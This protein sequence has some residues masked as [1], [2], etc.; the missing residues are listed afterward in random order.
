[1]KI[2]SIIA[3]LFLINCFF[4]TPSSQANPNGYSIDV[5]I[6]NAPGAQVILGYY[7]DKSMYPQDTVVLNSNG[8][9]L[10]KGNERLEQGMYIIFLPSGK[11]FEFLMGEDQHFSVA[12]DTADLVNNLEF[13]GS[14]ENELFREFQK[15]MD[16][17]RYY[18][19]DLQAEL[20]SSTDESQKKAIRE[21]LMALGKE[22]E[23][24][25][26]QLKKD[27]PDLFVSTFLNATLDVEVPE[28]PDG[29]TSSEQQMWRYNYY[30][31]HYFDNFKISD[32]RLLRSP[33]YKDKVMRYMEK[34]IPQIPDSIN[35]EIDMILA[36]ARVD[37]AV[38]RYLLVSFFNHYAQSK[39]MGMDAVTVHLGK[40]YYLTEAWWSSEE[41]L[42]D[43][44]E[45][46]EKLEPLLI[47]KVAPDVQ[48]RFV[49]A[50]HFQQA[51][52][53]TALKK[54][55]H[56]GS[57]F[58]LSEVNADF[59]VL[60]FWEATCGHCK[61]A[62][63]KIYQ[64]YVNELKPMG[65]EIVSISTLS[66]EDGKEKWVD[67]VNKNQTYDWI[68]AWNPYDYKYKVVYDIKTTPQIFILNKDKEIIGK[69]LGE[70][71]I[72]NLIEAY[73]KHNESI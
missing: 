36:E 8:Q 6:N 60:I 71:D 11:Y 44:K 55:P 67:F 19:E 34:V 59:T 45:K 16:S 10:L 42:S 37:S 25:I 4:F 21:K 72:K 41:F 68:N 33:L 49:P 52:N 13:K 70:D 22:R 73:K 53:D 3:G 62:I 38:Y 23:S 39:I 15:Y 18:A 26:K 51:A 30:K 14:Q 43:L 58:K 46:V 17:K 64:T 29:L 50:D 12:T 40:N 61:K 7:M 31:K 28:A 24:R 1:M 27:H 54:F 32:S 69:R 20:N 66:G 9:G 47:G 35:A 63:P 65:V 48:L 2:K 5:R 57:F 56:A